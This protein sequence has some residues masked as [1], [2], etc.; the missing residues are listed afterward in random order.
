[1]RIFLEGEYSRRSA[2]PRL[3]LLIAAVALAA[4]AP[5]QNL[6]SSS[7]SLSPSPTPI[8]SVPLPAE[9]DRVLRDYEKAWSARDA[10][11]LAALFAEDGFVLQGGKPPVRGRGAIQAAYEGHEGPLALRAFAFGVEGATGWILGGYA[12]KAGD[13]DDGKFTLTLRKERDGRWM[14]VSDMDNGNRPPR[15]QP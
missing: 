4:R 11:G 14:I 9:L 1:M 2:A 12:R 3:L 15:K 7:P 6:P 5:S 8:P 13:P 10:A